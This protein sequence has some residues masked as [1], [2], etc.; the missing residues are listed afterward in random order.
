[1]KVRKVTDS[2]GTSSVNEDAGKLIVR[3]YELLAIADFDTTVTLL[4]LE[5]GESETV[6]LGFVQLADAMMNG[7]QTIVW[8]RWQEQD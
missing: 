6:M 1:M 4:S 3:A 8:T 5:T 7:D 2:V